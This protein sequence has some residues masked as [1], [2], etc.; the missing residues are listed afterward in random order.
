[1]HKIA[2]KELAYFVCASGN[3]TN[4][5]FSN[6]DL[7]MGTKCHDY[8]QSKYNEDSMAE[9]Y[10][11]EKI[12]YMQEEYLLH[13]FIDGVLDINGEKIIEEI[14]STTEDLDC[15]TEEYHKEHLAQLKLYAYLYSIQNNME[16]IH[17]RL[18]YISIVDYETKSF[19]SLISQEELEN[20]F[21]K[22]LEEYI[23]FIKM[24]D[25]AESIKEKTI[26]EMEFP[27]KEKRHGQKE[28]MKAVYDTLN[29]EDILYAIAPTGIGKTMATM[30]S[31][32]KSLKKNDKL[33]YLTAKGSG[34]N[35]PLDAIKLLSKNGLKIKTI[36]ITAKNKICNKGSKS[37]TPEECPFA[38]GY[39]DRL[40]DATI[41]IF[42]E[43]DIY[44]MDTILKIANKHNICAFEFSLYLSYFC[45][46]IIA[47]YNYG[48]DPHAHLIRYFDDDTYNPKILVDEAHNLIQRS[49]DMYSAKITTEDLRSLRRSLTGLKPSIRGEANKS[50]EALE[51]YMD[52]LTE[53]ALI[54]Q[55]TMDLD[56]NVFL[57]NLS[58]KC[59]EC[60]KENKKIKN[61]DEAIEVY[62][63]IL[64]FLN[65][66]DIYGEN[67]KTLIKLEDDIISIEYYCLDA[68]EYILDTIKSSMHG[69]VF[70][71]AT[72]YPLEYHSNL[73]THGEGK[74]IELQSP[75]DPMNL[76][77][78][79]NNKISTKYK[80]RINTLDEIIETID[81]IASVKP[82][83][84]IVFFP[85]YQY[86]NM[87]IDSISNT[88]YEIIIQK[89]SMKDKEKNEIIDKFKNTKNTKFGFFV[90]G[91]AFSEGIDLIGD[92]L[93]GVII[94]GVGLPMVCSE[95][96]ILKDHF[97]LEYGKGFEYAYQYPGFTKVIQ[98][99]GRVIR[100][101]KDMGIAILMDERFTYSSYLALF[102]P[103]WKN[104]KV[105][106]N[107]YLL[108]KELLSFYNIEK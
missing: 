71:S 73:I 96:D 13:G 55:N 15:I 102:P 87:V 3:L 28:L 74:Y 85:S 25:H 24:M 82:G 30:F 83:N 39:F 19:D 4:E 56:F 46:V 95:N 36:D 104:K 27:F 86:M 33:F 40:K 65:V 103:H 91:G 68:S 1:M 50:I 99:V 9:V 92:A 8:L 79:I 16:L 26:E 81:S 35:A 67:H 29:N 44:D 64:S 11:K 58:N 84:Y 77:I 37:C 7:R 76:D 42:D 32:L 53:N 89:N 23:S 105:I 12:T 100:D 69:I 45:D 54:C 80:N 59:D 93:N 43:Y 106:T 57:K 31:G 107:T 60:F 38:L 88:D 48:F 49:K 94:V 52:L 97:Q 101:K 20:F 98:A 61:K 17:V 22:V 108:K 10:I 41:E 2:I 47:D 70:F 62:Y 5:Y 66:A 34:K 75:F 21:F 18:T 78:I 90:M 14:K 6:K 72:L 63:K 51:K